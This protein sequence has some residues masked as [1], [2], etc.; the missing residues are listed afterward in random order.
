LLPQPKAGK[1][2]TKVTINRSSPEFTDSL[3]DI[4]VDYAEAD[5]IPR[6]MDT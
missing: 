2:F 3:L 1:H 6:V 5:T 4:A